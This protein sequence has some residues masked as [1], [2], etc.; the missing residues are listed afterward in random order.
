MI[1]QP[2]SGEA[3]CYKEPFAI[4]GFEYQIE[5][6]MRCIGAG[7]LQSDAWSAADTVEILR[8]LEELHAIWG[9]RYR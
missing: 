2:Y 1:Y 4:N 7:K 3:V 6:A 8:Q 9:V 5:E